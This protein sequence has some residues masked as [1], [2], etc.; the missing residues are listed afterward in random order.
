MDHRP[1]L[2]LAYVRF[3]L[4]RCSAAVIFRRHG[5]EVHLAASGDRS[6]RLTSSMRHRRR[7]SRRRTARRKRLADHC[8]KI[9]TRHPGLPV[10][11][12]VRGS[13]AGSDR[14][15]GMVA[16]RGRLRARR[17][18]KRLAAADPRRCIRRRNART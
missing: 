9:S 16:R 18:C 11:M 2:L 14:I 1:R 7:G 10:V 12:L 6:A 13:L 4:R 8:A 17:R 15:A 5:W 3:G